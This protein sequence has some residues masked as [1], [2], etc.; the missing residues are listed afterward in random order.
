MGE[1]YIINDKVTR[2]VNSFYRPPNDGLAWLRRSAEK[3]EVPIILRDAEQLLMTLI[4]ITGSK[5]I[6]EVGTAVGYSAACFAYA[7]GTDADI[8]TVEKD[9]KTAREAWMNLRVLG[10][11]D[12]IRIVTGDAR[13]ELR[14]IE[15][16]FDFVFI[17]AGKS[18][19]SEFW[20]LTVSHCHPGSMIVCDNVL[21]RGSVTD[22]GYDSSH[23]RHHTNIKHMRSFIEKVMSDGSCDTALLTVGD[24]MTVSRIKTVE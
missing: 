24:G 9:E 16:I 6:L 3:N 22:E 19:Y 10:L 18:H 7:A 4:K 20:D 11:D 12:R 1:R 23:R 2:Y 17:D 14:K 8:I 5:R 13:E 21:L 15:G